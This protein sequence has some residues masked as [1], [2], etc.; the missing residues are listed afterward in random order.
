MLFMSLY[1]LS[2]NTAIVLEPQDVL[3]LPADW[4]KKT[5]CNM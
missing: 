3:M 1:K 5:M 2:E 4:P